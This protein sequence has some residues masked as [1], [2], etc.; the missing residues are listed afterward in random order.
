MDSEQAVKEIVSEI[1]RTL[2]YFEK[3][4]SS[5][6]RTPESYQE[7]CSSFEDYITNRFNFEASKIPELS[8]LVLKTE[9]KLFKCKSLEGAD[10][11]KRRFKLATVVIDYDNLLS[12]DDQSLKDEIAKVTEYLG[13]DLICF[14]SVKK[15]IKLIIKRYDD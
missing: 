9:G 12:E 15:K 5:A 8:E 3:D 11:K 1:N 6:K 7:R 4:F 2:S 10:E 13:G 14:N